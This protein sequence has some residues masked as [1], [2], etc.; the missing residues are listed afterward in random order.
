MTFVVKQTHTQAHTHTGTRRVSMREAARTLTHAHTRTV[1]S[2]QS[3][4]VT[5]S[6]W[7]SVRSFCRH[8]GCLCCCCRRC[9][10]SCRSSSSSII[11]IH[12]CVFASACRPTH[13]SRRAHVVTKIMWEMTNTL[14]L[15]LLCVCGA[16]LFCCC[17]LHCFMQVSPA[18]A[19]A[20]TIT[21]AIQIHF[22]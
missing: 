14:E 17:F 2:M 8:F 18:V 19:V 22:V 4:N 12:E 5:T 10:K 1:E 15:L 3:K 11:A 9:W 6:K 20:V 21:N 7:K 16:C 13:T